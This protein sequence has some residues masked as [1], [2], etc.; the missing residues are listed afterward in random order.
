MTDWFKVAVANLN[1]NYATTT[2]IQPSTPPLINVQHERQWRPWFYTPGGRFVY[3]TNLT[4]TNHL[5]VELADRDTIAAINVTVDAQR[6]DDV[7]IHGWGEFDPSNV[8]D[9]R[10][11]II[12][13]ISQPPAT[14]HVQMSPNFLTPTPGASQGP[15]PGE[16]Q[17]VLQFLVRL[18]T[19]TPSSSLTLVI[20]WWRGQLTITDYH[21]H[22]T[23]SI[24]SYGLT[25]SGYFRVQQVKNKHVKV[26]LSNGVSYRSNHQ[27]SHRQLIYKFDGF[28]GAVQFEDVNGSIVIITIYQGRIREHQL[29]TMSSKFTIDR[30][31]LIYTDDVNNANVIDTRTGYSILTYPLKLYGLHWLGYSII[32]R[33]LLFSRYDDVFAY[34]DGVTQMIQHGTRRLADLAYYQWLP[35]RQTLIVQHGQLRQVIA[36]RLSPAD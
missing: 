4:S 32:H 10:R 14:S 12:G 29:G 9:F 8:P 33:T 28:G 34:R 27:A 30:Q 3:V 7:E 23:S 6:I 35:W 21:A 25:N 18:R 24:V 11:I 15:A 13:G 5:F 19:I 36:I 22:P 17:A 20:Q 1:V 16:S 26:T 31:F 2:T